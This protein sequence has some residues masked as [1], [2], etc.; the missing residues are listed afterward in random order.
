[1]VDYFDLEYPWDKLPADATV[2]DLG[3][4][5]GHVSVALVKKHP[6]LKVT[7]QDRP[8]QM[9]LAS[10]VRGVWIVLMVAQ[11]LIFSLRQFCAAACPA[12]VDEGR[13]TFHPW[14]AFA[15]PPLPK[16]DVYY[17]IMVTPRD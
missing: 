3:G 4:G 13:L 8:D 5:I 2:A 7:V 15:G 9:K 10:P 6:H 12:A 14:N 1:M 16:Q 11:T 17:V